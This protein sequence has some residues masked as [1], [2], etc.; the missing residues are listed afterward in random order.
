MTSH[1][2]NPDQSQPSS[3][4]PAAGASALKV[5]LD[6]CEKNA[7]VPNVGGAWARA[8]CAGAD[9]AARAVAT[10]AG[11]ATWDLIEQLV[12][13]E[14]SKERLL[15]EYMG[16]AMPADVYLRFQKL[17]DDRIP[18]LQ[19]QLR[20]ALAGAEAICESVHTVDLRTSPSPYT[21]LPQ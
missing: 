3:D 12:Q 21:N 13:L 8:F 11:P 6:T 16:K 9:Y 14:C 5:Y 4:L 19:A 1:N 18:T 20:A 15:M 7:I 2:P 10:Q 17:R